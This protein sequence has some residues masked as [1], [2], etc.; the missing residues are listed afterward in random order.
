MNATQYQLEELYQALGNL[1]P[2]QSEDVFIKAITHS[3]LEGRLSNNFEQLEF[4]GDAVL[5][6]IVAE[7]LYENYPTKNEGILTQMRSF[8]VSRKQLNSVAQE[9]GLSKFI[10]HQIDKDQLKHSKDI[11][12]NV[13]ESLIG[14]YYLDGG[15]KSAQKFVNQ[16]ILTPY[17]LH[18]LEENSL[19]PKSELH[20]W[21]QKKK[22]NLEFVQLRANI[23]QPKEFAVEVWIEGK[24]Y[25]E[26]VGL[27]KKAAEK[28]AAQKALKI[29]FPH[30][31]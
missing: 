11:L 16:W 8:I 27:N 26:G 19:N 31:R 28:N 5:S 22:K 24:K 10:K 20:E 17:R 29:L 13:I 15:L 4:L 3:S 23:A 14:A 1:Y 2:T 12:G 9:I 30:G 18:E 21:A 25:S 6:L 7:Y